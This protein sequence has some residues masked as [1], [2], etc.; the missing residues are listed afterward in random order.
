[1]DTKLLNGTIEVMMLEVI[2]NGPTYGYEITQTVLDRSSGQFAL[3]EG[4]LYPALHRLERDKMLEAYWSE[5]E[6]RRRKYYKLTAVGRKALQSRKQ[7]WQSFA[8]AVNSVL[9]MQMDAV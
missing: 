8:N 4:S 2:S 1:M 6:G 7:E 5:H 3:K 9:G